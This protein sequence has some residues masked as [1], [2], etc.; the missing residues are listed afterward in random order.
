MLMY[1]STVQ[2]CDATGMSSEQKPVTKKLIE[3]LVFQFNF[4]YNVLLAHFFNFY[5]LYI[6]LLYSNLCRM[7]YVLL[8][9]KERYQ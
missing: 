2:E 3:Q 9:E 1:H 8:F 7:A 5:M 6:Q 4:F